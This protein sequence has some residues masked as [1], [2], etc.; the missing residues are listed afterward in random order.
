MI[1]IRLQLACNMRGFGRNGH[2]AQ[3]NNT[4]LQHQEI[5]KLLRGF[6]MLSLPLNER[7]TDSKF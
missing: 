1:S 7:A 3:C 6:E 5:G 4:T 2:Y